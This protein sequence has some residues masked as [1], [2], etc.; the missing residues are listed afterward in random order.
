MW[1]I[2][3]I[4]KINS[5]RFGFVANF[6]DG[7]RIVKQNVIKEI[8][9]ILDD[10]GVNSSGLVW[11]HGVPLLSLGPEFKRG[12]VLLFV[13]KDISRSDQTAI[14][15]KL[16]ETVCDE[17]PEGILVFTT[18]SEPDSFIELCEQVD[19]RIPVDVFEVGLRLEPDRVEP[20]KPAPDKVELDNEVTNDRN[21]SSH[22][23]LPSEAY[24]NQDAHEIIA[25]L[26]DQLI[27]L[28]RRNKLLN[29]IPTKDSIRIVQ[30]TPDGIFSA[31]VNKQKS[32]TLEPMWEL[33]QEDA[34]NK[35]ILDSEKNELTFF[36][37]NKK[38]VVDYSL[39]SS[40]AT[41]PEHLDDKIQTGHL[42]DKLQSI[43]GKAYTNARLIMKTTGTNQLYLAIG[44]LRW[45]ESSDSDIDSRA[46]LLLIPITMDRV[47]KNVIE[48]ILPGDDDFDPGSPKKN[49]RVPRFVYTVVYTKE[50][51]VPNSALK[52]LMEQNYDLAL[53]D[54]FGDLSNTDDAV[55]KYLEL[56]SQ[57][58]S[59][60]QA[61]RRWKVD[62]EATIGFFD[63]AQAWMYDDL[64]D[65]TWKE[66]NCSAISMIFGGCAPT[67]FSGFS[68]DEIE[69]S[70]AAYDIP[71]VCPA[72]TSQYQVIMRSLGKESLV[73]EGPPGTGKSQ[74]IANII[75]AL[76]HQGDKV[77]FL[78]AKETALS[79]VSDRLEKAGLGPFLLSIHADGK[80]AGCSAIDIAESIQKRQ[81]I[82]LK[83]RVSDAEKIKLQHAVNLQRRHL[84]EAARQLA[85]VDP[86]TEMTLSEL[87]WESNQVWELYLR[88]ID[89]SGFKSDELPVCDALQKYGLHSTI[90]KADDFI[91]Y[92]HDL[93]EDGELNP[94]PEWRGLIVNDISD[95]NIDIIITN[96]K[97]MYRYWCQ[98]ENMGLPISIPP[99]KLATSHFLNLYDSLKK[100]DFPTWDM[101]VIGSESEIIRDPKQ[102]QLN[103]S[104]L[105]DCLERYDGLAD[106]LKI[107]AERLP[108]IDKIKELITSRNK[109]SG[110]HPIW[111]NTG[112]QMKLEDIRLRLKQIQNVIRSISKNEGV[113]VSIPADD[114][115][116][117]SVAAVREWLELISRVDRLDGVAWHL[118][119]CELARPEA[120]AL[121]NKLRDLVVVIAAQ[122]AE[123]GEI[124]DFD[125]LPDTDIIAEQVSSLRQNGL[126][127]RW[128][129]VHKK[130]FKAVKGYFL[131]PLKSG[132]QALVYLNRC[133]KLLKTEQRID[134]HE[135]AAQLFGR[136]YKGCK[137]DWSLVD[138]ATQNVKT[139]VDIGGIKRLPV[140]LAGEPPHASPDLLNEAR[141]V[142]DDLKCLIDTYVEFADY[143]LTHLSAMRWGELEEALEKSIIDI[144]A[145]VDWYDTVSWEPWRCLPFGQIDST[146]EAAYEFAH[147]ILDVPLH[148]SRIALGSLFNG[149][150]TPR[151]AASLVLVV[152]K[153]I[154]AFLD[155][156]REPEYG[157]QFLLNTLWGRAFATLVQWCDKSVA[158]IDLFMQTE[159]ALCN[160]GAIRDADPFQPSSNAVSVDEW[161][162]IMAE[163]IANPRG[164][165]QW[166]E[167]SLRLKD[168]ES[169]G[170][171]PLINPVLNG[172]IS[173]DY[174]KVVY[175][176]YV[177]KVYSNCFAE[178]QNIDLENLLERH[179]GRRR[180]K[181]RHSDQDR[182]NIMPK[183]II[184]NLAD[185]EHP[186]EG[187]SGVR[188][189]D[190]YG[191]AL[192]KQAIGKKRTS[193][194]VRDLMHRSFKTLQAYKPCWLMSPGST[195]QYLKRENDLFDVL[196]V[197]EA[198]QLRTAEVA[199]AALR[200]KRMLIFGDTKQ[201]PPNSIAQRRVKNNNDDYDFGESILERSAMAMPTVRLEW[202]YRS[203][204]EDLIRYSN[205]H[206]YDNNL[207]IFPTRRPGACDL[208]VTYK[209]VGGK[210]IGKRNMIEAEEA[211][212]ELCN[213]VLHEAGKPLDERSS[214]GVVTMNADQRDL[215]F[216]LIDRKRT[217]SNKLDSALRDSEN[218]SEPYFVT[219]LEN[220]QGDERDHIIL[221]CTYGPEAEGVKPRNNFGPI[222]NAGGERRLNVLYTRSR[223]RM[224]VLSS[225]HAH[226][227]T[228]N[229]AGAQHFRGFI[230]YARTGKLVAKGYETAND[231]EN[232]FE[233]TVGRALKDAGYKISYQ[234]GV[235]GYRIDI[236]IHDP[237][238]EGHYIMAIECDGATYHSSKTARERDRLRQ[239][240]LEASGW[241]FFR[242]WSTD[243]FVDR[244]KTIRRM[245]DAVQKRLVELRAAENEL[246]QSSEP[247]HED[248]DSQSGGREDDENPICDPNINVQTPPEADLEFD[249]MEDFFKKRECV[250]EQNSGPRKNRV[251]D[252]NT[253][254][255]IKKKSN[256][257]HL[258]VK[259]SQ[260]DDVSPK[261]IK[262]A[263][264]LVLKECPN[265]SCT[266]HSITQRVLKRMG[267][268]TRGKPFDKLERRVSQCMDYLNKKNII[269]QYKAKNERIR[270][271]NKRDELF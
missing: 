43:A 174:I 69:N 19:F 160:T 199:A 50:E 77:L 37:N 223:R 216:E 193:I 64:N 110:S 112:N 162:S 91:L 16:I 68:N 262:N 35:P 149:V 53:P 189:G 86:E 120:V 217:S 113:F 6:F 252:E 47:K 29:Y 255:Q 219:N 42:P 98:I 51:I 225:I 145:I 203:Q 264:C 177:Y 25:I 92:L 165:S 257:A 232:M 192:I 187:N 154:E 204:H 66:K 17:E 95:E 22:C 71:L 147:L 32:M 178:A 140:V 30:E 74:T 183:R 197:D 81:Q 172:S 156:L 249:I 67:S 253:L 214:A 132:M 23:Q 4:E 218:S 180:D 14:L 237:Q 89:E 54:E 222:N 93:E 5:H 118:L 1:I 33:M 168:S 136:L 13:E 18:A 123:L 155:T 150:D 164:L 10:R 196:I 87:L 254:Q 40:D 114:F 250:G 137:T 159:S 243:W 115:N 142:F 31:L 256:M 158:N 221:C 96:A 108:G 88:E 59:G 20:L 105:L 247:Q 24:A 124:I 245:L 167:L 80:S 26:K 39:D 211:V 171:K 101:G 146:L 73:V 41:K 94:C 129:G 62:R 236:A 84:N 191:L 61:D 3:N 38:T 83:E 263:I 186:F 9:H 11:Q 161:K 209:Y 240:I 260:L 8:V 239:E 82:N 207:V 56:V 130:A 226:E 116:L 242:V 122:R 78:A 144:A 21:T 143:R 205:Y 188:I 151:E 235:I 63:F 85:T 267:I 70:E 148:K 138:Q 7:G 15:G 45:Y 215:V 65:K 119:S 127:S 181:F 36:E 229:S 27:D 103:I 76:L 12:V 152:I 99:E 111:R 52:L 266:L 134:S 60:Y 97:L 269:E 200:C 58:A 238:S 49:R 233:E 234:V 258:K 259:H 175:K 248:K 208:G 90:E 121:A 102:A 190:K 195:S 170:F 228:S 227:I 261:D 198:S 46:P 153:S 176:A 135:E 201:M 117:M 169:L 231:A 212:Q 106:L 166:K 184:A 48:P 241:H 128:F 75:A 244:D 104:N 251:V 107:P 79:V 131:N 28:T 100:A 182:L 157:K 265:H 270:L 268:I 72:D 202:H 57:W 220:V 246:Q 194:T 179:I 44:F 206:F 125:S 126:W 55:E 213:H 139:L 133:Q 109:L 224:T 210:F 141:S 173:L 230:E 34:N 2:F 163:R 185:V 271:V